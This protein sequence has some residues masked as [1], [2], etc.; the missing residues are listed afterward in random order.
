V[1]PPSQSQRRQQLA[2]QSSASTRSN[3]HR[4]RPRVIDRRRK[5]ID[6]A[7][8]TIESLAIDEKRRRRIHTT[9]NTLEKLYLHG[10]LELPGVE[11]RPHLRPI[12]ADILRITSEMLV[13]ERIGAI[14]LVIEDRVARTLTAASAACSAYG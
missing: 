3:Q 10:L 1:L 12:R 14:A 13:I 6:V 2:I 4:A 11:I 7:P 9:P 8:I 5:L